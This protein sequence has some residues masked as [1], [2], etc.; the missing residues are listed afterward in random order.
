MISSEMN[1]LPYRRVG[2]LLDYHR[3]FITN[4]S[5]FPKIYYIRRRYGEND[6]IPFFIYVYFHFLNENWAREYN[7]SE[8]KDE[9][10]E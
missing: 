9:D 10:V 5:L 8:D 2:S 6:C 1:I 7:K 3:S 4:N